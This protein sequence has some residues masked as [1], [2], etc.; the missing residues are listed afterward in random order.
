MFYAK[1]LPVKFANEIQKVLKFLVTEMR[2]DFS[3]IYSDTLKVLKLTADEDAA[4][5]VLGI[6]WVKL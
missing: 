1:I 2:W 3:V 5:M 4:R 6:E